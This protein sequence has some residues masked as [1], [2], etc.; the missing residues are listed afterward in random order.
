MRRESGPQRGG[1][2]QAAGPGGDGRY[3]IR[4]VT[5]AI[6]LLDAVAEDQGRRTLS[7]LARQTGLHAS[8]TLRYLESLRERG[9]IV[10]TSSGGYRLGAR[11]FELG[12]AF[13]RGISLW[14]H[15]QE[16]ARDLSIRV[17]E[18]ASVGILDDGRI[19]YIAI[20]NGQRELGIQ[21]RPGT[22]HPAHC[23][24]LGKAILACMPWPA[25]NSLLVSHPP[26]KLTTR[27]ITEPGA[28]RSELEVTAQRG[29]AIDDEER[30]QGV[31][32]VGASIRDFSGSVAG[33]I[34]ISG[35]KFRLASS[36]LRSYADLVRGSADEAS[37]R[38]GY[39]YPEKR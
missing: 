18:T 3:T 25:V 19:L 29:F 32:C 38:L 24:A 4:A 5:R 10:Q 28:L 7:D 36:Q 27:T 20:E 34:S 12:S 31:V 2:Q 37:R 22:R 11:L 21:W 33:A 17:N 1:R 30:A 39:V 6:D 15:A 35:P 9:L 8:T 26:E 14:E 16:I 23:T 13:T